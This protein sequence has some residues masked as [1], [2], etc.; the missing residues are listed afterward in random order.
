[1]LQQRPATAGPA[2]QAIAEH[3]PFQDDAFDAAMA[4]LTVHHWGDQ[5]AGL[6]ELARVARKR[7]VLVTW[8]PSSEGFW[9]LKDY[10]PEFLEAD[11]N[12]LPPIEHLL[13]VLEDGRVIPV[14]IPHDCVDGFLGAY[15]RRPSAYL[16]PDIRKGISSFAT[17]RDLSPLQRLAE[18]LE[19]ASGIDGTPTCWQRRNSTSGI[20]WWWAAPGSGCA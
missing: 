9:L 1:M 13:S 17:C 2:T 18:H 19:R 12:R 8:D 11:R 7:I 16:N 3:L 20:G 15:W 4:V 10:F 5:R 6:R 14:P